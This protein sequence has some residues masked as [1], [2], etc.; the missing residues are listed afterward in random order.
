MNIMDIIEEVHD[1]VQCFIGL[2]EYYL[3]YIVKVIVSMF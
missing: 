2:I 3:E 1:I